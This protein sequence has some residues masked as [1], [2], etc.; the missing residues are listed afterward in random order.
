MP[1]AASSTE[2]SPEAGSPAV[3]TTLPGRVVPFAAVWTTQAAPAAVVTVVEPARARAGPERL[4]GS[5]R[6]A[7]VVGRSGVGC[8]D[9]LEEVRR[10]EGAVAS[11]S[12]APFLRRTADIAKGTPRLRV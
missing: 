12:H 5:Q 8:G 9:P 3:R 2:V 7:A 6:L 11:E 4:V 10:D 1:S